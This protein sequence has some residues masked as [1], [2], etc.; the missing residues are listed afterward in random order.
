MKGTCHSYTTQEAAV[1]KTAKFLPNYPSKWVR[2]IVNL[3]Q[4]VS[5]SSLGVPGGFFTLKVYSAEW[6]RKARQGA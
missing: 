5:S 3:Q 1:P 2:L 6:D 4:P